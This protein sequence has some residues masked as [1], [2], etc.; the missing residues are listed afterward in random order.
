MPK[1][2]V[3]K[4]SEAPPPPVK[5][6]K[7]SAELVEALKA[8]KKD[9]VLQLT[10]DSGKSRRGLKTGIGRIASRAGIKIESWSVEGEEVVYVRRAE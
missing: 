4:A 7:A 10:P 8:L 1:I 9:E 3:V 5:M 6:S 2:E